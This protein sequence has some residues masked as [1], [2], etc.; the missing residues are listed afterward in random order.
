MWRDKSGTPAGDLYPL[1]AAR[2][3][4]R[5]GE[6]LN[7]GVLVRKHPAPIACRHTAL[8]AVLGNG[9]ASRENKFCRDAL[10]VGAG[11]AEGIALEEEYRP[12]A[13]IDRSK[14]RGSPGRPTADDDTLLAMK[15]Y[16][17]N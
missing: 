8:S 9:V 12:E 10:A 2:S 4:D 7:Q 6:S 5:T 15:D 1:G 17:L 14:R 16:K 13:S 11:A 3:L